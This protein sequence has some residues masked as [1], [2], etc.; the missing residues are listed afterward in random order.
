[1][2]EN[3]LN[4]I[5][6]F[7]NELKILKPKHLIF[8]THYYYD[9][10]LNDDDFLNKGFI[11]GNGNEVEFPLTLPLSPIG[12]EGINKG[13]HNGAI[14]N[15]FTIKEIHNKEFRMPNGRKTILWWDRQFY[16]GDK[17]IMRVLRTSHPERQNKEEFVEKIA[18]WIK[19]K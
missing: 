17:L 19:V 16:E 2:K 14:N 13:Y 18:I 3:C 8:F 10:F 4:K 11:N 15:R 6:V 12:G 1:M 7:W 5:G 9:K